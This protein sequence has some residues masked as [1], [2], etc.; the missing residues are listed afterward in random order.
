MQDYIKPR[1]GEHILDLG[2][3]PATI[4]DA[5]PEVHYVGID[6]NEAHIEQARGAYGNRGS[7]HCGD[8]AMLKQKMAGTFDLVLCIGLL[9]HI[10]DARVRE[11]ASLVASYLAPTGRFVAIDPVYSDDQNWI[12]RRL[13]A[14][15][16]GQCVR[17]GRRLPH[18]DG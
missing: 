2:C 4:L 14:A 5:M 16:S 17:N 9:H 6:L 7:F 11:L 1:K 8:F 15:D 10:E 18:P 3:G 13:A 12:A